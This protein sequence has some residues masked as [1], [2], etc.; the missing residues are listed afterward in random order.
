MRAGHIFS[1]IAAHLL[2]TAEIEIGKVERLFIR[3]TATKLDTYWT[4]TDRFHNTLSPYV[5]MKNMVHIACWMKSSPSHGHMA[6]ANWTSGVVWIVLRIV[7]VSR[8]TCVWSIISLTLQNYCAL[9][10]NST[11]HWNSIEKKKQEKCVSFCAVSLISCSSCP[12]CNKHAGLF[13]IYSSPWQSTLCPFSQ[14]YS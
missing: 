12:C 5:V 14:F 7:V 1:R 13:I 9:T 11:F 3:S 8:V 4:H 10:L 2:D 6:D